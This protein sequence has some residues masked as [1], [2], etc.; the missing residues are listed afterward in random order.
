MEQNTSLPSSSSFFPP[1][2]LF[3]CSSST[4]TC[5]FS[6][7]FKRSAS[8]NFTRLKAFSPSPTFF[9]YLTVVNP[10]SGT[11]CWWC[12]P[13]PAATSEIYL[14]RQS[15]LLTLLRPGQRILADDGLG[16]EDRIAVP[17]ERAVA[18]LDPAE[19]LFNKRLPEERWRV[20]ASY[21]RRKGGKSL[22]SATGTLCASTSSLGPFLVY[23]YNIDVV[24]HPLLRA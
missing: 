22:V 9:R 6:S 18:R 10:I 13:A 7:A 1:S 19:A 3:L 14:V 16:V 17:F 12:G 5:C 20:E 15:D 4:T 24:L 8:W 2:P 11:I 21:A 23:I